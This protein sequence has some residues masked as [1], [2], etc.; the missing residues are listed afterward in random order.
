M[1][2]N[3]IEI[4]LLV[5]AWPIVALLKEN[6]H[7]LARKRRDS[8]RV[9]DEIQYRR[10]VLR[11]RILVTENCNPVEYGVRYALRI[12][13]TY[14]QLGVRQ[15]RIVAG[16]VE[17]ESGHAARSRKPFR[18][19]RIRLVIGMI[20]TRETARKIISS[21]E[22]NDAG[23]VDAAGLLTGREIETGRSHGGG[24]RPTLEVGIKVE[25]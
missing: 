20:V 14:A 19:P 17:L 16:S 4:D 25:E 11:F 23:G 6:R 13:K 22:H 5:I 12:H 3:V 24:G 7:S 18:Y 21:I 1:E 2:R 9:M 10:W 8:N 15:R